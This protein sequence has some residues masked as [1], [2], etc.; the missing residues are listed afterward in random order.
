M[1][2]DHQARLPSISA[3]P[4]ASFVPILDGEKGLYPESPKTRDLKG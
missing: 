4:V 1:E 2:R 3:L